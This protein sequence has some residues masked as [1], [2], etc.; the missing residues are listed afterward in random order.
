[1]DKVKSRDGTSIAYES[2]G[3]GAPVVLVDGA[4]CHRALGPMAELAALL[5]E[6]FRVFYY[7][8]RGRGD[9]G[10]RAPYAVERE[11]EDLQAV[12]EAA[13]G[14]AFVYGISSGAALSL[15]AAASGLSIHKLALYE[16][17]F[18]IDQTRPPIP[19][20]YIPRLKNALAHGRR[21]EAVKLF[22][23]QAVRVPAPIVLLMPLM[24]AWSKLKA[25]AHT[26]VHDSE[27]LGDTGS[28]KP[29]PAELTT[30]M[31]SI[32]MP[33]LVMGGGKSPAWLQHAVEA[34]AKGIPHAK[35]RMLD[36]QT[37]QVSAKVLAPV[38]KEFFTQT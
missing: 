2:I 23:T 3:H 5:A 27:I 30:L 18:V 36:G 22:L 13:G 6:R 33:T 32:H 14:S 24:P 17:P 16:T 29:L 21:G 31:S 34:V 12:I 8:R 11:V 15:R 1:M 4:L 20:D 37:H 7:D 35:L 9:S 26:L 10:D 38:L 25:A 28:G 19:H